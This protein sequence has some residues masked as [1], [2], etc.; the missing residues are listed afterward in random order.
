MPEISVVLVVAVAVAS[1]AL[2]VVPGPAV[3]YILT[4]S[5]SQGPRA[6]LVSV[7]GI[8]AG[9][10][11]HV[12][13]A[14]VGL[15]SL[16]AASATAFAVVKWAGVAYLIYLGVRALLSRESLTMPEQ[17]LAVPYR[18]LFRDGLIVNVFNPKTALF[19]LAFLP[20]FVD[21]GRGAS[22]TQLV[23]FGLVFLLMTG[24]S[25]SVIAVAGGALAGPLR[26]RPAGLPGQRYVISGIYFA[27][28]GYAALA[29]GRRS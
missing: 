29:D 19:F 3:L 20:Q 26:R 27:L 1:L 10:L 17:V 12:L 25:D 9:T 4:A 2:A 16:I 11:V 5:V 7:S 28:G 22:V 18:R 23:L 21:P 6:G 24:L 8:H 14:A 15:S 13:A